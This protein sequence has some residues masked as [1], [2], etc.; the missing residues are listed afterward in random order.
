MQRRTSSF[1][2]L[3]AG[4]LPRGRSNCEPRSKT[5][6]HARLATRKSRMSGDNRVADRSAFGRKLRSLR[7]EPF[8]SAPAVRSRAP[9]DPGGLTVTRTMLLPDRFLDRLT[10]LSAAKRRLA[11]RTDRSS[12]AITLDLPATLA[13]TDP[14]E[15]PPGGQSI[16]RSGVE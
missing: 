13:R 4:S 6:Q 1:G 5:N 15:L 9:N 3:N 12:P 14:P 2:A 7:P 10:N 16:A 11:F 8:P